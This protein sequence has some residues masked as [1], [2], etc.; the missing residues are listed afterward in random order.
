MNF[1]R[2]GL[3]YLCD[4]NLV[5]KWLHMQTVLEKML[6]SAKTGKY[7]SKQE[8]LYNLDNQDHNQDPAQENLAGSSCGKFLQEI[9]AG[10]SCRKFL[11]ENLV[12]NSCGKILQEI[13][14]GNTCKKFLQE[15][16]RAVWWE[17]LV[18]NLAEKVLMV[19][20]GSKKWQRITNIGNIWHLR[21]I[22]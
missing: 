4:E 12:G 22:F 19:C 2:E 7:Y 8:H 21:E 15:I 10:K 3:K 13:L 18:G 14:V 5:P 9:L 20:N 1:D 17:I 16:L 6:I 11:R